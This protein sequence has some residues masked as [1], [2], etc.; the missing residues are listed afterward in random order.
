[1]I[2]QILEPL[3]AES[4]EKVE[5]AK[6]MILEAVTKTEGDNTSFLSKS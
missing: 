3:Q 6:K 2:K 5:L 1:M 4:A